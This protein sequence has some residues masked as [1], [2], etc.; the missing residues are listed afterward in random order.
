MAEIVNDRDDGAGAGA[1][2]D[3]VPRAAWLLLP[4]LW[5]AAALLS[6]APGGRAIEGDR[7]TEIPWRTLFVDALI[8]FG[9][10]ALLAPVIVVAVSRIQDRVRGPIANGA[11][12]A[13]AGV[14]FVLLYFVLRSRLVMPGHWFS[15][16]TDWRGLRSILPQTV[17]V[18]TLIAGGTVAVRAMRRSRAREREAAAHALRASRLESQLADARLE[19]LRG[20]LQPHFLF[21]TL[22]AVSALIDEDP[23][24][25]R[26]MLTR[27]SDLLRM[28]LDAMAQPEISLAR[29]IEWLDHY[30]ELQRMRFEDRLRVDV[31]V[32]PDAGGARIPPLLLQP[33][34]ENAIEHA[35]EPRGAGGHIRVVATRGDGRL[36]VVVK[37]DGPGPSSTTANGRGIGM[38]VTRDRLRAMYGDDASVELRRAPDGGA[39]AV[40]ELPFRAE[41]A[42]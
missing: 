28:A 42:A 3:R 20:Q 1:A 41:G 38:R 12:H 17:M 22:N 13:L 31:D 14:L 5:V 9:W 16:A 30:V 32:A 39:E 11:A 40:V 7:I 25:A 21:N 19:V 36:R 18:Y 37:D 15:L 34:V 26:R 8:S 24:E 10:W 4:V 23:R 35:V 2:T 27:L 29:E 6:S 33:L